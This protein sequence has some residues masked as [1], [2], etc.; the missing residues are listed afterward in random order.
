[1]NEIGRGKMKAIGC[2]LSRWRG[3]MKAIGCGLSRWRRH[4]SRAIRE[5]ILSI[6]NSFLV[7]MCGLSRCVR[8]RVCVCVV[9]I[10]VY[11]RCVW[12]TCE[13]VY[14]Y[15]YFFFDRVCVCECVCVL[16]C[17]RECVFMCVRARAC[18]FVCARVLCAGGAIA[19]EYAL[20]KVFDGLWESANKGVCHFFFFLFVFGRALGECQIC[21]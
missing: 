20:H 4:R 11:L 6:K 17:V 8:E 19:G 5:Y 3:T 10:R 21:V 1:M 2:G 18:V 7:E 14:V 15:V 12:L 13:C 16:S 9:C